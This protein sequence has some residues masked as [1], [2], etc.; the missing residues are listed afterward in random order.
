MATELWFVRHGHTA[1][2]RAFYLCG[3]L[4]VPLDSLGFKQARDCRAEL[5]GRNFDAVYCSPLLR[6]KQT[7]EIVLQDVKAPPVINYDERL[8]ERNYGPY[9]GKW[10]PLKMFKFWH[11]GHGYTKSRYGEESLCAME[12]RVEAFI[13][14]VRK[15]HDG[16][17]VIVFSHSGVGTMIDTILYDVPREGWFFANCHIENGECVVFNLD[18]MPLV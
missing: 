9:E 5:S 1:A 17:K 15:K 16:Q 10:R 6:A 7:A 4:D 3:N 18:E 12:D 13:A 2:N 14:D 11:Y 8:C